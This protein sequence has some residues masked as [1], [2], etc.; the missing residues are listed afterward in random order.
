MGVNL[1]TKLGSRVQSP[2]QADD[3]LCF[4]QTVLTISSNSFASLEQNF[5]FD[6]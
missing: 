4:I 3:I 2:P 6:N 1:V 5:N